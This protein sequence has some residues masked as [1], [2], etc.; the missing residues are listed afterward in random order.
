[1][2]NA[3]SGQISIEFGL[4]GPNYAVA[5]ACATGC[6]G[7]GGG[8]GSA[9]AY[10]FVHVDDVAHALFERHVDQAA[11]LAVGDLLHAAVVA[12]LRD[13]DR[14]E[15][16]R[17]AHFERSALNHGDSLFRP[18]D[19]EIAVAHLDLDGLAPAAHPVEPQATPV[20]VATIASPPDTHHSHSHRRTVL[21]LD[22]AAGIIKAAAASRQLEDG[23]VRG[24]ERAGVEQ[25]VCIRIN[26]QQG[27]LVRHDQPRIGDR[28]LVPADLPRALNRVPGIVD[29]S[30]AGAAARRIQ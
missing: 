14:L 21:R 6:A 1:M 13:I 11:A 12:L 20:P 17:L 25:P 4:R 3:A 16:I 29:Q 5:T 30:A 9:A 27:R 15:K 24:P 23:I 10:T 26:F 19:N 2:L 7:G 8:F 22:H 28:D 18:R